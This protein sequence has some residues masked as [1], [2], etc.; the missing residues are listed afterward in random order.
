MAITADCFDVGKR[1]RGHMFSAKGTVTVVTERFCL[2]CHPLA[3]G[4]DSPSIADLMGELLA[5]EAREQSLRDRLGALETRSGPYAHLHHFLRCTEQE[6][7]AL[8]M[9]IG[10]LFGTRPGRC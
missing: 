3:M 4:V 2:S 7:L 10:D 9:L 8:E 6:H 5:L 1:S